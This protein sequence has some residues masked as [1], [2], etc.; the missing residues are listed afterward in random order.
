MTGAG[1]PQAA[2]RG[3]PRRG[4]GAR[5]RGERLGERTVGGGV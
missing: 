3:D 5:P 1:I 2:V 4:R